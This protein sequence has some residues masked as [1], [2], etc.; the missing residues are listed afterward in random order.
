MTDG[1]AV[2]L[3]RRLPGVVMEEAGRRFRLLDPDPPEGLPDPARLRK[4]ATG[5]TGIISLLTERIDRQLIDAAP[6]LKGIANVAVGY[7]NVDVEY[8]RARGIEV[9]HTPGVLTNATADLAVGLILAVTRRI[10]EADR[11]TR[12]G[13][14]SSWGPTLMLGEDL[15]GMRV[16]LVGMGRIGRAVARRLAGFGVELVYASRTPLP[17]E[18][19]DELGASRLPFHAVLRTADLVSIHLPLTD[20][21]RRLFS[22]E[23]IGMMKPGAYLVNTARGPVVDEAALVAALEEGRLAGAGLDVFEEEPVIHPGLMGREDVVLLPHIGSAGRGTR[24]KMGLMA[25]ADLAAVLAGDEPRF[26]V[27]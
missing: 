8:A 26:P 14:F 1:P 25:V 15:E 5:A 7:D 16:G 10:V 19:E 17:A 18:E 24:E 11:F 12:Q 6:L 4:L 23:A 3:T 21:T 22:R 9:T 13:R 20:E 27:P 2:L